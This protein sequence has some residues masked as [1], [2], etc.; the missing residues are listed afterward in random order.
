MGLGQ[1]RNKQTMMKVNK[2]EV[3]EEGPDEANEERL[4]KDGDGY[5]RE[6]WEG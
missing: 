6:T 1:T 5:R 2:E 3:D 4:D